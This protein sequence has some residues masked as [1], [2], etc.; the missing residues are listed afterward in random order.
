MSG[1]FSVDLNKY[2]A[3]AKMRADTVIRMVAFDLFSRVIEKTPVDLGHARGN[4]IPMIGEPVAGEAIDVFDKSGSA[5]IAKV[6]AVLP[7][8]AAGGSMSIVNNV[9]YIQALENG[10]SKQAP[11]GMIN[12]SLIEVQANIAGITRDNSI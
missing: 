3:K 8:L 12:L 11:V 1:N 2:V 4:W 9:P 10:H 7:G 6:R 5:T